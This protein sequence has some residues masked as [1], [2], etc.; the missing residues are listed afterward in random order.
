MKF[1]TDVHPT[2]LPHPA[3]RCTLQLPWAH[4]LVK[5]CASLAGRMAS[6]LISG[7][8][9]T[10]KEE[11]LSPWLNLPVLLGGL[12]SPVE[13]PVT[14]DADAS[15]PSSE[16]EEVSTEQ[17]DEPLIFKGTITTL[18]HPHTAENVGYLTRQLV[19]ALPRDTLESTALG[20]IKDSVRAAGVNYRKW[21]DVIKQEIATVMKELAGAADAHE[22]AEGGGGEVGLDSDTDNDFEA[23]LSPQPL[24]S[25]MSMPPSMRSSSWLPTSEGGGSGGGGSGGGA[26][27][28]T[29]AEDEAAAEASCNAILEQLLGPAGIEVMAWLERQIPEPRHL[30]FLAKETTLEQKLM[31][32]MIKHTGQATKAAHL[33]EALA[34]FASKAE[35]VKSPAAAKPAPTTPTRR[36]GRGA[37]STGPTVEDP[38]GKYSRLVE[39][40]RMVQGLRSWLREQKSAYSK[41]EADNEERREGLRLARQSSADAKGV[42]GG[43]DDAKGEAGGVAEVKG[44][45]ETKGG[46]GLDELPETKAETKAEVKPDKVMPADD[47]FDAKA[48][49]NLAAA[50][51]GAAGAANGPAEDKEGAAAAAAAA[52]TV[53]DEVDAKD[54]MPSFLAGSIATA[55]VS[56]AN[57]AAGRP[58]S[59]PETFVTLKASLEERL[60]LLL[61]L[62]SAI[63]ATPP[64]QPTTPTLAPVPAPAAVPGVRFDGAAGGDADAPPPP[65]VPLA[66]HI[67]AHPSTPP[68]SKTPPPPSS[69]SSSVRSTPR[70]G[71][72]ISTDGASGGD[73]VSPG[74]GLGLRLGGASTVAL[75]DEKW[76]RVLGVLHA[77]YQWRKQHG[78]S[79]H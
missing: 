65:V 49:S 75:G 13:A 44:V 39:V 43:D 4:D 22:R 64:K 57:A 59:V 58:V 55:T 71:G 6:A 36:R 34:E 45:E 46:D 47:G 33:A 48:T 72:G 77:Q 2:P 40:W 16:E 8:A 78:E 54:P 76:S 5:T 53:T 18:A 35:A 63:R 68:T 30:S 42:E 66:R 23:D 24:M 51:G 41:L 21:K 17:K 61:A 25:P 67:S 28:T 73:G 15:D 20:D 1:N 32:S 7:R 31:V 11:E 60:D 10:Q 50:A 74:I 19:L 62:R 79:I 26:S 37:V 3:H 29:P 38:S 56:A 69:N 9:L 70:D 52:A 12:P 14:N 27:T